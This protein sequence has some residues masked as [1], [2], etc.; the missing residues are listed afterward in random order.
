MH[1]FALFLSLSAV[2]PHGQ[3]QFAQALMLACEQTC[4]RSFNGHKHCS[5][6]VT[7]S[8]RPLHSRRYLLTISRFVDVFLPGCCTSTRRTTQTTVLL[9]FDPIFFR[10]ANTPLLLFPVPGLH[11][12]ADDRRPYPPI[13]RAYLSSWPM[14][15]ARGRDFQTKTLEKHV[16]SW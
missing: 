15:R 6:D 11:V 9:Y 3:I 5:G 2:T 7:D 12:N 14:A 16:T 8:L 4:I 1:A 13:K 10:N